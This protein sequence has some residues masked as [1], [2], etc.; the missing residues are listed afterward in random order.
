MATKATTVRIEL[1]V[2]KHAEDMLEE[3]GM[4]LNTYM[5]ASVK[6]L[7]R[8]KRVPFEMATAEYIAGQAALK[9]TAEA[10]RP[11][12]LTYPIQV[13]PAQ[14]PTAYTAPE[15]PVE[16]QREAVYP[17][18]MVT[19]LQYS[20]VESIIEKLA[21]AQIEADDPDTEL[22]NHEEVFGKMRERYAY[23]I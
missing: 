17:I 9:K 13:S 11:A 10:A 22:L 21:Q 12:T 14:H 20:P 18:E 15:K 6:A 19:T 4:D 16:V 1:A 2:R 7:V 8:E 3:I 5:V 23:E